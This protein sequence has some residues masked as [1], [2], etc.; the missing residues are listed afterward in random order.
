MSKNKALL[1]AG[2]DPWLRAQ[3][4]ELVDLTNL[5]D[6]ED[7]TEFLAKSGSAFEVVLTNSG[8]GCPNDIL[9]SLP[10]L[11]LILSWGVG[12]DRI[13]IPY[14]RSRNIQ[15]V[16]TPDVLTDCVA[17]MAMAMILSQ[18]RRLIEAEAYL[19]RGEWGRARLPLGRKVSGKRLGIVGLGRI[20][21]ELAARAQPFKMEVRYHNRN[22]RSDL[23]YRFEPDLLELARWSDF[24]VILCPGGSETH[25]LI[26]TDVLRALGPDSVLV[27]ISRG[28]VVDERA[29][30][31]TLLNGELGGA[32]LDVF[33]HEPSYPTS[34]LDLP[35]VVMF[36]HIG[37]STMETRHAMSELVLDNLKSYLSGRPLITPV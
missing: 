11:K 21:L 28:S 25:E 16:N 27:N 24:L 14:V 33:Q 31:K 2:V 10:N 32:A 8:R 18:S 17:D 30:E 36:P 19:R 3:V 35:Q 37:S 6:N 22:L 12:F 9:E 20:G 34:L 4:S 5:S 29:L 13:D 23:S 1:V 15:V 26:N 7:R